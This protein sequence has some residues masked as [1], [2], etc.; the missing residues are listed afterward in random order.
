MDKTPD[1]TL[2][3]AIV[4]DVDGVLTDGSI[5]AMENG[6]QVRI[7]NIKDGYAIQLAVKS[8]Y[9]LA[10]ISGGSSKGV[11]SR[12]RGLGVEHIY[13]SAGEKIPVFNKFLSDTGI[14][15]EETLYI[16]DDMPDLPVMEIAGVSVA[17][18]DAAEDILKMAHYITRKNG[19]KGCVR[20]VIEM[21]MKQQGRWIASNS[22]IW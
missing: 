11:A 7:M 21:V 6:D 2:I 19:G 13:M 18:A 15:P 22:F 9:L 10:I 4:M 14:K 5:L 16:G 20:E 12:M 8:G 17:P 3:K 1:F